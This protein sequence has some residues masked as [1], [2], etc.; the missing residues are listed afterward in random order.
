MPGLSSGLRGPREDRSSPPLRSPPCPWEGKEAPPEA[1]KSG[2]FDL[3]GLREKSAP[4][5]PPAPHSRAWP[6]S[7]AWLPRACEPP[8][9]PIRTF[10]LRKK[11]LRENHSVVGGGDRH[12]HNPDPPRPR[13]STAPGP[14]RQTSG[15]LGF[16]PICREGQGH[17]SFLPAISE[18]LARWQRQHFLTR[19]V[20]RRTVLGLR[21]SGRN[22]GFCLT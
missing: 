3:A 16:V 9:R 18:G 17:R 20:H 5:E 11:S 21:L 8:R 14:R 12:A 22:L 13:N 2:R 4:G 1:R 19:V 10:S 6:D 7:P 15:R